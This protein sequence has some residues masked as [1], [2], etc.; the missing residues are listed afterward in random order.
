MIT[1]FSAS[2]LTARHI[3][4]LL[5]FLQG[6]GVDGWV[7]D[8]VIDRFAQSA[9]EAEQAAMA[10]QSRGAPGPQ[11][12]PAAPGR[13][14]DAGPGMADPRGGGFSPQDYGQGP[15]QSRIAGQAAPPPLNLPSLNR[16]AAPEPQAQAPVSASTDPAVIPGEQA[17]KSAREAAKSAATLEDLKACLAAFNGC[18]LRLTAKSL[19]F[20][21]GNP[22]ARVMLVGEAP[23]RD[24]DLSGVP[25]I[26]RS[27]QLL[28]RMLAAIGLD[29]SSVYIANVVPWRPPGNRT[30]TPQETEICRP[31]IAR[32]IELANP[33][34]LV[35]LGAAS[36]KALTGNTDGIRRMRGRWM[37]YDA[38]GRKIRAIAT[39]HP[40]YLLRSPLEKRLAWRDFL[41]LRQ[42][43]SS[44]SDA[45][46]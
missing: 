3:E 42:A 10:R 38:G 28:D 24:E 44:A 16:N 36:A 46:G 34:F 29:R 12:M 14:F 30:P 25:F 35:F 2:G 5:D 41:A 19:V 32:Q 7:E 33:D 9:L 11:G 17:V 40:A 21:D 4:A 20:A 13:S 15:V 8:D 27:G 37:D 18:N 39:Y 23:G 43:L 22:S 1:S 6:A 31:F 26:G 45:I